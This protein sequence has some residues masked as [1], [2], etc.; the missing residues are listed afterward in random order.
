[1][2]ILLRKLAKTS[3]NVHQ[4]VRRLKRSMKISYLQITY[5]LVPTGLDLSQDAQV[6]CKTVGNWLNQFILC[7]KKRSCSISDGTE[8]TKYACETQ[9]S[10]GIVL[11]GLSSNP[12]YLIEMSVTENCTGC[13]LHPC[14]REH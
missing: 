12:L 2:I 9:M 10:I 3:M 5:I 8:I 7:E 13:F 4:I 14:A 1:M 11:A 6:C